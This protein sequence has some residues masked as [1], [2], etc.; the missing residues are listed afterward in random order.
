[1]SQLDKLLLQQI[2]DKAMDGGEDLA[3]FLAANAELVGQLVEHLADHNEA[4]NQK[5]NQNG[6]LN[7]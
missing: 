1:M 3:D 2:R 6:G 5:L 4:L 7:A